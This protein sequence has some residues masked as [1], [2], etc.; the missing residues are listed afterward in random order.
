MVD[1]MV[2]V[3]TSYKC[4]D[5]TLFKAIEVMDQYYMKTQSVEKARDLHL[6]GVTCILI[7]NKMEEVYP[8]KIRILHEKI[9]HKKLS[10]T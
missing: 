9:A 6:V 3:M 8:L 2:E 10:I 7:A 4:T 5:R 1:W